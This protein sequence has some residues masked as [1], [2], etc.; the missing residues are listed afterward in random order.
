MKYYSQ[1]EQDKFLYENY[2][3]DSDRKGVFVDIGAYDGIHCSNTYFFELLG[4]DGICFEPIPTIFEQLKQ[5]R[6]CK[7]S[8][9][10]IS[11]KNGESEF[12]C[13][14]GYSEMLSGLADDYPV[15]HIER[16]NNEML[17]HDQEFEYIKVQTLKFNEA[18]D[19]S[20]IDILSLDTEGS[21]EKII[22]SIDFNKVVI[23]FMTVEFNYKNDSLV[24]FLHNKGFEVIKQLG[25]DLVFKNISNG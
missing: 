21:E 23:K 19:Y 4:W 10:A 5:N 6:K 14:K 7:V 9:I 17:E 25:I 20:E 8:N 12:F 2:Y 15:Q 13:I 22:R 24:E 11:D 18:V 1:F 3:K 16:I